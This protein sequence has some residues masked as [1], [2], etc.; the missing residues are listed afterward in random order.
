[1]HQ[2]VSIMFC[3]QTSCGDPS[4]IR[5][6]LGYMQMDLCRFLKYGYFWTCILIDSL[7]LL[8][9]ICRYLG[10]RPIRKTH[11]NL[12]CADHFLISS[13]VARLV[14]VECSCGPKQI[15][16]VVNGFILIYNLSHRS[17]FVPFISV[18]WAQTMEKRIVSQ[19]SVLQ[20]PDYFEI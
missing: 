8:V 19:M 3:F 17:Y 6:Y 15:K 4:I 1:M 13:R 7:Y 20:K 11:E 9:D 16:T 18:S 5:W 14:E 12:P 10:K 2:L